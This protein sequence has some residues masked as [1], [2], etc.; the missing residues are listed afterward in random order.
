MLY[1]QAGTSNGRFTV[2]FFR[3][4]LP[5]NTEVPFNALAVDIDDNKPGLAPSARIAAPPASKESLASK[6]MKNTA[7]TVLGKLSGEDG[8]DIARGAGQ[9]AL[10]HSDLGSSYG[11]SEALLLDAGRDFEVLVREAF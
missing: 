11:G 10:S 5:D 6:V 2:H 4:R 3:M 1:G 8:T 9:T 7:G